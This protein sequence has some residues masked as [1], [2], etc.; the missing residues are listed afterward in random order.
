MAPTKPRGVPGNELE[1]LRELINAA[2]H[3]GEVRTARELADAVG[4]NPGV[5]S[6][7]RRGRG[8]D[9]QNVERFARY[10]GH[11]NIADFLAHGADPAPRPIRELPG[12]AE[13]FE[14]ARRTYAATFPDHVWRVIGTFAWDVDPNTHVT[15]EL[16]VSLAQALTL[17]D[18]RARESGTIRA[19]AKRMPLQQ[20]T[21]RTR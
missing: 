10:F 16:I 17:A 14:R 7:F 21:K 1:F 18:A 6:H 4:I 15:S 3:S 11:D 19:A 5:L 2:L 12:F 8:L 20:T 13:A 9:Y